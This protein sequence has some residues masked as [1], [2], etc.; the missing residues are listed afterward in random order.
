MPT[1]RKR[2][3]PPAKPKETAIVAPQEQPAIEAIETQP[4]QP[5]EPKRCGIDGCDT[6]YDD[7]EIMKRHRA[8]Q[9]G[10]GGENLNKP[11]PRHSEIR[12]T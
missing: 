9:H 1:F 4:C 2:G 12:L 5:R 6:W 11:L 7:P 10:I 8:R 3:R